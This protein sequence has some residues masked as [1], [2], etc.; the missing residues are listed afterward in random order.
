VEGQT[1]DV[2]LVELAVAGDREALRQLLITFAE[3]L[4]RH[5]GQIFP[6]ALRQHVDVEDILQ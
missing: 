2:A 3:R 1:I 4:R 6:A 5:I